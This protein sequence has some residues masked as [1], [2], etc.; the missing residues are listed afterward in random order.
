M[1]VLRRIVARALW[2]ISDGARFTAAAQTRATSMARRFFS[3]EFMAI[4]VC[5]CMA[6]I[7]YPAAPPSFPPESCMSWI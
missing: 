4:F 7:G 1:N 2:D 5:D 6:A 3:P